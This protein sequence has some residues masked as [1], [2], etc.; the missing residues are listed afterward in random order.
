MLTASIRQDG[1][2]ERLGGA[3]KRFVHR[4]ERS[5][6]P[7]RQSEMKRIRR[8]HGHCVHSHQMA[9]RDQ[10]SCNECETLN[11]TLDPL[12]QGMFGPLAGSLIHRASPATDAKRASAQSLTSGTSVNVASQLS[13]VSVC[14]SSTHIGT[15]TLVSK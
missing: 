14:R 9:S 4:G 8:L 1:D 3:S 6:A 10:V 13:T 11:T 2:T 12:T 5:A 7:P 15:R